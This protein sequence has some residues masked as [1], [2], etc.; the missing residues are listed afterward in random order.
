MNSIDESDRGGSGSKP[1]VTV[2]LPVY[3]GERYLTPQI[4]SILR[5]DYPNFTLV[6]LDD[7]SCDGSRQ[8][9]EAHAE[10]DGRMYVI[11]GG[12]NR[13]LVPSVTR[14]LG[15]VT[16][17][18]FALSDQD[19]VW[20]TNKLSES[21]LR[22]QNSGKSLVFSDV[23][24]IDAD[25]KVVDA[26]YWMSRQLKP[27]S[28]QI[29]CATVFANPVLGHTIVG[30]SAL[31]KSASPIPDHLTYYEAWFVGVADGLSGSTYISTQLGSYRHHETNVVGPRRT[32]LFA[33]LRRLV[34]DREY[35]C[36]RQYVRAST[37][38]ALAGLDARLE[39]MADAYARRSW[40]RLLAIPVVVGGLVR[41]FEAGALSCHQTL[42][43]SLFFMVGSLPRSA[44]L[45]LP[46][47]DPRK[48]G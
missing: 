22:L 1:G 12:V 19:D 29:P 18:Y 13:G 9:L 41:L 30:S 45:R 11:D 31:A 4:Q 14:L 46:E 25:G 6:A 32:G 17:P 39:P 24:V 27:A 36:R 10:S 15:R 37:L 43:E 40:R 34:K 42:S 3:N 20:D 38:Q 44:I 21:I 35:F 23:R 26:S 48:G 47:H 7:G 28:V 5:Q 16:T 2:L 8:I 33:K